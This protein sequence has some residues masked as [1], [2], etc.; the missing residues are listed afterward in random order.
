MKTAEKDKGH[1]G[2][3]RALCYEWLGE[4][5][6]NSYTFLDLSLSCSLKQTLLTCIDADVISLAERNNNEY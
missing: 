6:T 1:D 2:N 5:V 4:G 3:H